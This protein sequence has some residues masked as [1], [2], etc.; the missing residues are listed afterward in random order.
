MI[1]FDDNEK[2]ARLLLRSEEILTILNQK[3]TNTQVNA[4]WRPEYGS[5]MLESSPGQPFDGLFKNINAVETNMRRRRQ[6]ALEHLSK[7][8]FI[9]T[10]TSFPRL[11]AVDFT[12]PK[13]QC[14]HKT[15]VSCSKYFPDEAIN[16]MYPRFMSLTHNVQQRRAENIQIKLNVFKDSY[17]KIPVKGAPADQSDA[18]CMDA[19]GFG[20]SCCCLQVTFQV[21]CDREM[22]SQ[23]FNEIILRFQARNVNEAR[24]LYDQ[25]APICPIM[26]ALTAGAPAFRGYLVDSDSRWDILS[27]SMDCRTR[28]E[29]GEMPL[30]SNQ[31]K[32][33]KSRFSSLDSYLTDDGER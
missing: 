15:S 14:N 18:V 22:F 5:F 29:R 20:G 7:D 2:M 6:E 16:R 24:I 23:T 3:E 32:I 11:G 8:E 17:T 28:E 30:K 9:M 27:A 31:F 13:S 19:I 21:C 4:L 33:P 10:L 25:L 12:W 1:K 26:L